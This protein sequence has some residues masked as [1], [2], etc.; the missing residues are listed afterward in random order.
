MTGVL[1]RGDGDTD[2]HQGEV[3]GRHRGRQ[4]SVS[5]EVRPRRQ[6]PVDAA[7]LALRLRVFGA[8]LR[9]CVRITLPGARNLAGAAPADPC[10]GSGVF[11]SPLLWFSSTVAYGQSA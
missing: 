9:Q 4:P 5:R 6:H 1:F 10:Y 7:H 8:V 2:T 3:T 11:P